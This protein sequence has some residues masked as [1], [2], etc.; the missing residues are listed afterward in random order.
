PAKIE[1]F[2]LGIDLTRIPFVPRKNPVTATKRFLIAGSFREK[3][4]IP[5]A[6][7][8]LGLVQRSYPDLA[9]TVIGDSG[10]SIRD[11][12]EKQK[13]MEIVERQGLREKTRFLGYQPYDVLI[14][15]FY[16][17]DVF[18]SPSVT[19][20][21]GDTEGGAPVTV[22]EAAAS[23]MP[24]ASTTH[25]DI[26]FVLSEANSPYLAPERDA[27]ALHRAIVALLDREDWEMLA[28]ANRKMLESEL[29]VEK[30]AS[31]LAGIYR[32]ILAPDH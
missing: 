20:S 4:G 19:S 10:G 2:R 5:Y 11:N 1:V 23:G 13:I 15:E 16:Q 3:K 26:P 28:T 22:I 25:C 24:V 18:V 17:H 32:D 14:R 12:R 7:E 6:L 9:I 8:A 21:D 30:Q 31:Q 27:E 29:D